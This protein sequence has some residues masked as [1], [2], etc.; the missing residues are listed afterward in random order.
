MGDWE[1]AGEEFYRKKSAKNQKK[2]QKSENEGKKHLKKR[3]T[4]MSNK[5]GDLEEAAESFYQKQS[6][7][8]D[9]WEA[10][11]TTLRG[12]NESFLV[13]C[14]LFLSCDFVFLVC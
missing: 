3:H 1:G 9:I 4:L 5:S 10:K 14:S 6:G 7:L 13:Y 2:H 11:L 12:H 8:E